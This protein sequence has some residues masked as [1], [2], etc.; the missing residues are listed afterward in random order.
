MARDIAALVRFKLPDNYWNDYAELV[1]KLTVGEVNGAAKR[2]LQPNRLTWVVV[3]DRKVME[4][5]VRALNFGD[6]SDHRCRR[7]LRRHVSMTSP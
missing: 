6:V 2:L 4:A 5:Q 1:A 7:Q 3:G